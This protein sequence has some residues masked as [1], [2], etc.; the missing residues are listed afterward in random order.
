MKGA[1]A[2]ILFLGACWLFLLVVIG[3]IALSAWRRREAADAARTREVMDSLKSDT[4]N[5]YIFDA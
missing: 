1:W 4:T 2:N 5:A 3:S